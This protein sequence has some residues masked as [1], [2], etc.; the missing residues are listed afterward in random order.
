MAGP[1]LRTHQLPVSRAGTRR[2]SRSQ[3][4]T[5]ATAASSELPLWIGS[6]YRSQAMGM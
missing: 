1:G 2:P 6:M 3:N 5:T 4:A